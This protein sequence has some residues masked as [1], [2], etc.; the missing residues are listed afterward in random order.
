MSSQF[1][2]WGQFV[3]MPGDPPPIKITGGTL[4]HCGREMKYRLD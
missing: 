4:A 1:I 3:G 2:V